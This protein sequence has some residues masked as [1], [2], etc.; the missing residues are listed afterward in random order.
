MIFEMQ[1]YKVFFQEL[2]PAI[3]CNLFFFKEK[4]KRIS[5]SIWAKPQIVLN[6]DPSDSTLIYPNLQKS[7]FPKMGDL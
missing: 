7:F 2:F 3:R 5:T 4:K 1:R 6:G